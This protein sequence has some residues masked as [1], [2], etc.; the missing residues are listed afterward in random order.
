MVLEVHTEI[1]HLSHTV[2]A[3]F[4]HGLCGSL[5]GWMHG[6]RTWAGL[7]AMAR[8]ATLKGKQLQINNLPGLE[9]LHLIL[10]GKC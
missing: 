2:S 8:R 9:E 10:T 7:D 3:C 1:W 4:L 6:Q 5:P